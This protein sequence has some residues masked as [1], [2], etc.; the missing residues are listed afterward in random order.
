MDY[1]FEISPLEGKEPEWYCK[2]LDNVMRYR[3]EWS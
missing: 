3:G 2:N 1:M